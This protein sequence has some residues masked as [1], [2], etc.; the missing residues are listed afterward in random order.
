MFN[1][2]IEKECGCFKKSDLENNVQI[3]IKEDALLKAISMKEQMNS[4]FCGKHDFEV[5]E[6]S[7]NFIISFS[8]QQTQSQSGGCCGGGCGHH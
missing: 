4:D 6:D 7:S 3:N 1:I 5:K 8:N 2:V